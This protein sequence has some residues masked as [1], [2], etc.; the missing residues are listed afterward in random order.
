MP[1]LGDFN[2]DGHN[3]YNQPTTL[4]IQARVLDLT[5]LLGLTEE[6]SKTNRSILES[7][8]NNNAQRCDQYTRYEPRGHVEPARERLMIILDDIDTPEFPR[9]RQNITPVLQQGTHWYSET[10]QQNPPRITFGNNQPRAMT[11]EPPPTHLSNSYRLS[12]DMPVVLSRASQREPLRASPR[13]SPPTNTNQQNGISPT[14]LVNP[15]NIFRN[16]IR[17]YITRLNQQQNNC[18]SGL[19]L[20]DMT[21]PTAQVQT[22][23]P[24]EK[25]FNDAY[26]RYLDYFIPLYINTPV[27]RIQRRN[28]F[29]FSDVEE[30]DQQASTPAQQNPT[31]EK[32]DQ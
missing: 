2:I 28:F 4:N 19:A 26:E 23:T 21:T 18:L 14:T 25:K 1:S 17:R 6:E 3:L 24:E 31:Q 30:C 16:S 27:L 20:T 15:T 8:I 7:F 29:E 22:I 13:A 9:I 5:Y 10:K 11:Y 12:F 32:P